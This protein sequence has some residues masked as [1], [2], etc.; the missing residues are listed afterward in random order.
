MRMSSPRPCFRSRTA[1]TTA[2]SRSVAFHSSGSC[3][4]VDA[5][6]LGRLFILSVNRSPDLSGH[7]ATNSSY[8]TRPSRSASLAKSWSVCHF[9]TSSFQYGT[10][11]PRCSYSPAGPGSSITPSSE[12]YS[13]A[14]ILLIETPFRFSGHGQPHTTRA[15]SVGWGNARTAAANAD[16]F[17]VAFTTRLPVRLPRAYA[18]AYKGSALTLV[19]LCSPAARSGN[20]QRGSRR[21]V[22]GGRSLD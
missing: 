11:Q 2:P 13:A 17:A 19:S 8:V 16:D 14:T 12:R 9:E 6:N 5:T 7:A 10:V 20:A 1:S 4:V 22:S 3:K 18:Q 15:A 21:P